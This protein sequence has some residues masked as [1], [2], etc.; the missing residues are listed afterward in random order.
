MEF[1]LLS[2][3]HKE[4]FGDS[5]G[6]MCLACSYEHLNSK[7]RECLRTGM[8]YDDGLPPDVDI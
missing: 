8:P 6:N 3:A 5:V 4:K 7:I 2:D 1:R